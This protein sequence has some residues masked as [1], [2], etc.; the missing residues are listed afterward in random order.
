MI[1]AGHE[2]GGKDACQ[3][4]SG[5]PLMSKD[6]DNGRWTLIG[7]VSAGFSCAKPGKNNF[8]IYF[9]NGKVCSLQITFLVKLR[10]DSARMGFTKCG[11][12][13]TL[14]THF[15]LTLNVSNQLNIKNLFDHKILL[16]L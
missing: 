16:T 12:P 8:N 3:G 1:C 11:N 14:C 5:G 9:P 10:R 2:N 4:D 6:L 13:H 15:N 7:I